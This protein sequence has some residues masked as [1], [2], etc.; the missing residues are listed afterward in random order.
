MTTAPTAFNFSFNDQVRVKLT[1]YGRAHH[2]MRHAMLC[3]A[4]G[5]S[6]PYE[7]P[8]EDAQ[9]W[10]TWEMHSLMYEFGDTMCI[11]NPN[12]AFDM[13]GQLL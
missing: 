7:A 8:A 2:A 3:A 11:G 12:L 13:E 9:G 5:F 1:P 10:S 6:V 4:T